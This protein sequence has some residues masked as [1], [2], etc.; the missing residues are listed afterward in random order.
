M[1]FLTHRNRHRKVDQMRKQKS[2]CHIKE[3]EKVIA[4]ELNDTEVSTMPDKDFKVIIIKTLIRL[5]T[6]E[7][8]GDFQWR[9]MI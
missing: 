3:Q 9:Q 5:K 4:R 8:Q 2:K 6:A 1:A 7:F